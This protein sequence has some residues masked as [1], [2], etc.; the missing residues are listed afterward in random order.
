M[1]IQKISQLIAESMKAG[2]FVRT[3]TLR[4]LSSSLNYERIALQRELTEDDE[5]NVI[6]KQAKQRK[7]SIEAYKKAGALD[8]AGKEEEELKILQ[9]FLPPEIEDAD[10]EALVVSAIKE[11]GSVTLSD[12]GRII[13]L[14]KAKNANVDGSR[15]AAMVKSK[16]QV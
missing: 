12:M 8:R 10:L 6:R 16:L 14:V 15:V 1:I 9:E 4:M 7:D 3:E 2:N 11:A 13:G 5:L